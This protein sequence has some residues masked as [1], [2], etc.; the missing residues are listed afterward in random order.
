MKAPFL[1]T[2]LII[3]AG[4]LHVFAQANENPYYTDD[5]DVAVK[6]ADG[7]LSGSTNVGNRWY[8]RSTAQSFDFPKLLNQEMST[9]VVDG[10]LDAT[11]SGPGE[12]APERKSPLELSEFEATSSEKDSNE[13]EQLSDR[14][15]E[16]V[17]IALEPVANIAELSPPVY[18]VSRIEFKD[19]NFS[20]SAT[21]IKSSATANAYITP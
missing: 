13:M 16:N 17:A 4:G 6:D 7:K 20:G 8:N 2:S 1:I 14:K 5:L 12:V 9:E 3:I 18:E 19:D 10:A 11:A 15:I 21:D